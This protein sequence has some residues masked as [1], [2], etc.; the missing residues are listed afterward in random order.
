MTSTFKKWLNTGLI[1]GAIVFFAEKYH[2]EITNLFNK[3]IG[4][5]FGG[6]SNS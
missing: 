1:V 5:Y 6:S 3:Y 4:V 2:N